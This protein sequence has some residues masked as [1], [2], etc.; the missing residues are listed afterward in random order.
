M[1]KLYLFNTL[2]CLILSIAI[3]GKPADKE[4]FE[5][6]D[7]VCVVVEGEEPI[8]WS[9]IDKRAQQKGQSFHD[10]KK[11]LIRDRLV[12][13]H[14]KKQ[15]KYDITNIFKSADEHIASAQKN[16][17]LTRE[18]FDEVLRAPPYSMTFRQF[19]LETATE[20]LKNTVRQSLAGQIPPPSDEE[21]KREAAQN[22]EVTFISVPGRGRTAG[23]TAEYKKANEI[24][25]R[26][27]QKTSIDDIKDVYSKDRS[28]Y[29]TGPIAYEKGVLKK[30][31]EDRL[32]A[33][34]S[35]FVFGPFEDEGSVTVLW[36][37]KQSKK[38]LSETALEKLRKES[39]QSAVLKK[40]NAITDALINNST[41]IEKGCGSL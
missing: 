11:D 28:V 25:S 7:G 37:I 26:I 21:V 8:L 6:V 38:N 29:I 41:V 24:R 14:A 3:L 5:F 9:E 40:Y 39:Y 30:T 10:A 20:F 16:N 4:G 22:F 33:D 1:I 12:W 27:N 18:K 15:L 34:P 36:K 32:N 31:Y 19:R 23:L 13:V 17:H 35:A 2:C